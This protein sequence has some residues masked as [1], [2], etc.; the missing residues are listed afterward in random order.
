[1]LRDRLVGGINDSRLRQLLLQ[2]KGLDFAKAMQLALNWE[3]TVQNEKALQETDGS[4]SV[5]K[6]DLRPPRRDPKEKTPC[7][8]CGK[9]G[10][11]ATS[12]RFRTAKCHSCGRVGHLKAVCRGKS[13]RDVIKRISDETP[14][15]ESSEYVLYALDAMAGSTPPFT[16]NILVD[17]VP[18][19]MELDTGASLTI[20]PEST[21][22]CHWPDRQLQPTPRKLRTYT[23]ET[24]EIV[25]T[26][27]VHVRHGANFADLP[28]MVVS[29]EGPCLLGRNWLNSIHLDWNEIHCLH[30]GVLEEVL[31]RH[32]KVFQDDLGTLKDKQVTIHIDPNVSP[33]F[34]R[35]RPVPYS[36][37]PLVEAALDKL[38]AQGVIEPVQLSDWA[39]PI[40]PVL[41]TDKKTVRICGDFSITINKAAAW[42]VTP[43]PELRICLPS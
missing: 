39:A 27:Y 20:M 32:S 29:Q 4:D 9:I 33:K 35:A 36:M 43:Y 16:V 6:M 34:C 8:R 24:V 13:R 21:F 15:K 3:A 42:T 28:L 22:H 25:G 37:R 5:R 10:H 17:N 41:K 26:T 31:H 1:M 7:Y 23:G 30:D 11:A 40:V 2:E 14:V 18:L 38:V 19:V 12:C